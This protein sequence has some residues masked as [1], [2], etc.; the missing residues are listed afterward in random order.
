M[1]Y[2]DY[3]KNCEHI[4]YGLI[5]DGEGKKMSTRK[6]TTL[7]LL[8]LLNEGIEK[9]RVVIEEKETDVK[10]KNLLAKQIGIGAIIFNNLSNSKIKDVMFDWDSALNFQ[11]ETGPY[12]QYSYVRTRSILNKVDNLPNFKEIDCNLLTEKETIEVVKLLGKFEEVI[13]NAA[14]KN[15]PSIISRYLIDLSQAFSN[16]YNEHHILT[17]DK[18]IQDARIILTTYTGTI[19]KTG[20]SLL[21]M[22]APERM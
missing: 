8:E 5:L 6:G 14:D 12:V 4:C 3:A 13:L 19:L 1:G 18:K 16:F 22:E 11:G 7:T 21:G 17:E 20:M 2:A 15:E 9:A 10:D